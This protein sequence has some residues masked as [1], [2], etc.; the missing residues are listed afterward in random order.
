MPKLEAII[1]K[2]QSEQ[3]ALLKLP[4]VTGVDVGY[5]YVNGKRTKNIAIR[6]M[7]AKK[8]KIVSAKQRIPETIDGIKTDVIERVIVPLVVRKPLKDVAPTPDNKKYDPLQG[9]IS[10][11][12]DRSINGYV[13]AGTLGCVV[14]D[15]STGE[16]RLLSNFHVMAI[17]DSWK[18]GDAMD[19][20]SLVD[21]GS[22]SDKV[23]ELTKAI[24]SDHVDG[25][26]STV[27]G[28]GTACT[29]VDIG[30]VKGTAVPKLD[31]AVRK[32]GRTTL[33]THG[34]VDAINGTV[35]IDYGDG[36]GTKT[37]SDQI[38]IRP[39][40]KQNPMFSDHGDSGSVVVN[41]NNEVVGLLF[42]GSEDGYTY[43][44]VIAN[45]LSELD[46]SICTKSTKT[47]RA[48]KKKGNTK[49]GPAKSPKKGKKS[50]HKA[51]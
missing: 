41:A 28:R 1:Q 49:G 33:L 30:D 46:I 4:G 22:S 18:A 6:V 19:Q 26:L 36:I 43:I 29:I 37:L 20:P 13:F 21:G 17:D 51:K 44:N 35:K 8:K 3:D 12:P 14:K 34:F 24:L 9:G 2:K 31:D 23:G 16:E 11:G 10:I 25:A 42:A 32:R 39:D 7:V 5:K 47:T 45:V 27:N 48:P 15:N 40:T 50:A 38:G